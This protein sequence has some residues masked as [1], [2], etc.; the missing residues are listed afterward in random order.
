MAK[1][2]MNPV[3]FNRIGGEHMPNTTTTKVHG[4]KG[5]TLTADDGGGT[6][7]GKGGGDLLTGGAGADLLTGGRG[8]DTLVGGDGNDR[9]SGGAGADV[10]IGGA[11]KDTFLID[12][13]LGG[14]L[15]DLDRVLDFT[16]GEDRLGFGGS[17]SLAG[18]TL[19]SGSASDYDAALATATQQIGSGAADTVAI[20][21]GSDLLVF[22]D[23]DLSDQISGAVVLANR[24]IADLSTWDIF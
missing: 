24:T 10:L 7:T 15:S 20:Q 4:P 23:G 18:H 16:G 3:L 14:G 13:R 5:L 21:L 12:A 2:A 11:G 9:L 17:V 22:A 19:W 8:A 6:L 1:L